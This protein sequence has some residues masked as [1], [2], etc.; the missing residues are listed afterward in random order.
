VSPAT[1]FP[2]PSMAPTLKKA[3]TVTSL[4][5]P[6]ESED[7]MYISDRPKADK[8]LD[9]IA[10]MVGEVMAECPAASMS[11]LDSINDV[12]RDYCQQY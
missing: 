9:I 8:K 3:A 12:L 7:D 10:S 6:E 11:Q 2:L 5:P 1:C 4:A